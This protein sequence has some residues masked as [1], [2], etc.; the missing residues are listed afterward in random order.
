M[1][2]SNELMQLVHDE[3]AAEWPLDDRFREKLAARIGWLIRNDHQYL[4]NLF[5][6]IDLNEKKVREALAI[7]P[8]SASY[9]KLADMV[10]QRELYK[11]ELR[12]K[13]GSSKDHS[14][15]E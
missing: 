11:I 4:F 7:K 5:Y 12:K 2:Y 8:E 15:D 1:S 10:I 13:Y 14:P 6:R 9:E 3:K